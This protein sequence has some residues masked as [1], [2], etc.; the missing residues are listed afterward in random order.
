MSQPKASKDDPSV[1][2]DGPT[3]FVIGE[4][5]IDLLVSEIGDVTAVPG[6]GPFNVA[7][8]IARLGQNAT[9]LSRLSSDAFGNVMRNVLAKDRVSLAFEESIN[10]PTALAVVDVS[11][12]TPSYSFH[13]RDSA[14]FEI[15]SREGVNSLLSNSSVSAL[16]LGTL[17]LV[18]EPMATMLEDVVAAAPVSA[19]VV[20]DPNCRPSATPDHEAYRCRIIRLLPR[21]DIVKVSSEDLEFLSP[22]MSRSEAT[23]QLL[24]GGA[25]IVI[26]TD[27]PNAVHAYSSGD[28]VI[29]DVPYCRIEDTVGAGDALVGAFLAWCAVR[30]ITREQARDLSVTAEGIGAAVK[31][32]SMTCSRRGAETPWFWEVQ[33]N[34]TAWHE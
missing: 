5:L 12:R 18:V 11:S 31:I 28:E 17:G 7:R 2:V 26:V 25:A 1:G 9:L 19:L 24:K 30:G 3:T 21:V 23:T 8:T 13:L 33:T 22:H 10:L 29:I 27:G 16:Y 32:A 4:N 20:M 6:G 34:G 14:A 15:T